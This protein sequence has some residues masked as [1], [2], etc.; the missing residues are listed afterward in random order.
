MSSA[1]RFSLPR[2]A[3]Q[4]CRGLELAAQVYGA[5]LRPEWAESRFWEIFDLPQKAI[6]ESWRSFMRAALTRWSVAAVEAAYRRADDRAPTPAL[7][8]YLARAYRAEI[9]GM[10]MRRTFTR[11]F[12]GWAW[13][14]AVMTPRTQRSLPACM[15]SRTARMPLPARCFWLWPGANRLGEPSPAEWTLRIARAHIGAGRVNGDTLP[16]LRHCRRL[17]ARLGDDEID[18]AVAAAAARH[19]HPDENV[20]ADPARCRAKRELALIFTARGW[21]WASVVRTLALGWGAHGAR[22]RRR[23]PSTR[24]PIGCAPVKNAYLFHACV[25]MEASDHS[26]SAVLPAKKALPRSGRYGAADGAGTS[27]YGRERRARPPHP[28][29]VAV[30]EDLYR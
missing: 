9:G 16:H 8:S 15:L 27:L 17:R 11:R 18:A 14:R 1:A 20:F 6:T 3:A 26:E 21:E 30:W 7:L 22:M 29:A 2:C 25:L 19:P 12:S 10:R 28:Q 13:L 24:L 4:R 23:A 5:L